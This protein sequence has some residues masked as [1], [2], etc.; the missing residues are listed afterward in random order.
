MYKN[1]LLFLQ[2]DENKEE[3]FT[4][5]AEELSQIFKSGKIIVATHKESVICSNGELSFPSLMPCNHEEADSRL[6]L[7]CKDLA[8]HGH[9]EIVIC[10]VDTDVVIIETSMFHKLN[11]QQFWIE[12]GVGKSKHWLTIHTYAINLGEEICSGLLFWF[13]F[14]GCDTVS[15]FHG[16][17][18]KWLGTHGNHAQ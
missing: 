11:I 14:T 2:V 15:S 10:T 1:W 6:F 4:L 16:H 7:H 3:L 13:A 12:F 17:V 9:K 8:S 18:K 5:L